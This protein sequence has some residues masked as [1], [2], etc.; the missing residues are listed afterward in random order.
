MNQSM[1]RLL[2]YMSIK[3]KYVAASAD[4]TCGRPSSPNVSS[5]GAG[6][7]FGLTMAQVWFAVGAVSLTFDFFN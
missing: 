7:K 4:M 2:Q 3:R 1:Q 6:S 5:S